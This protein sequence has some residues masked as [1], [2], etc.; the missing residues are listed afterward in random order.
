MVFQGGREEQAFKEDKI[1]K[2]FGRDFADK[3]KK[4]A[5]NPLQI[6]L[7]GIM[8][9]R[10]YKNTFRDVLS[11]Y[12]V[13]FLKGKGNGNQMP[14]DLYLVRLDDRQGRAYVWDMDLNNVEDK[15]TVYKAARNLAGGAYTMNPENLFHRKGVNKDN[16][17]MPT[18]E[19][20]LTNFYKGSVKMSATEYFK[21]REQMK[22]DLPKEVRR[23]FS[24]C[25][26]P[27]GTLW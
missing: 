12:P 22:N 14:G 7:L 24:K 19:G 20:H 2:V 11:K 10:E 9:A 15:G 23:A 21:E 17:V 1:I 4:N 25:D 13:K 26:P 18:F 27:P 16:R 3:V 6:S 8:D 5:D